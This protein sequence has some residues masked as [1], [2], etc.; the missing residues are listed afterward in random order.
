MN[1][2]L[3]N[4]VASIRIGVQD[5]RSPDDHRHLSAVRNYYAGILLLAKAVLV[6]RFPNEDPDLLLAAK[7]RP[8]AGPNGTVEI[9]PEG[10][11]TIDFQTIGRRFRDL[12]I[13]FDPALLA[14]LNKIRN[15]IE[16]R[17]SPLGRAAIVE[18]IAKGFPAA[19]QLFRLLD[20][21]PAILLGEEWNDMLQSREL[22]AAEL[23]AC[24][25]TLEAIDWRSGT[26]S[27]A[28]LVCSECESN[29]VQ[30][31]DPENTVQ[32]DAELSCRACG[33]GLDVGDVIERSIDDAL[34]AEAY[35]RAKDAGEDGPYYPCPDC[36][37]DTFIDFEALCANCGF[38]YASEGRCAICHTTIPVADMLDDPDRTLCAYHQHLME[39][40]D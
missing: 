35:L 25:R 6:R 24:Q 9:V 4:A 16:H 10:Q 2:L 5:Y 20:E 17:F 36:G 7:L 23:A 37:K 15:D 27:D 11:T 28:K 14:G 40:D 39:K 34:G 3:D 12:G 18:A 31:A 8:Q 26:I 21:D 29:L 38:T 1:A 30:Q 22:F 33:A 32:D 19:G 13:A